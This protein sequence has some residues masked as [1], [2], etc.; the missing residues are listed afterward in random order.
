MFTIVPY[1]F[2]VQNRSVLS[3]DCSDLQTLGAN[4]SR[5]YDINLD[6]DGK[7]PDLRSVYCDMDTDGGGWTVSHLV[8]CF[9]YS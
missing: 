7:A 3:R 8:D 2:P 1:R 9:I 5:V 6:P 4:V